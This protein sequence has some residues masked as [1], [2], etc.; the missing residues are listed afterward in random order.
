MTVLLRGV[1]DGDN[2][3][4]AVRRRRLF[5]VAESAETARLLPLALIDIKTRRRLPR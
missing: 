4:A 5:F 1:P 3:T 2:A